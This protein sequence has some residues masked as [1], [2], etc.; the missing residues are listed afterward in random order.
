MITQEEQR[1]LWREAKRRDRAKSAIIYERTGTKIARD[2]GYYCFHNVDSYPDYKGFKDERRLT[3][4]EYVALLKDLANILI[5]FLL[6]NV[7]F[8]IVFPN[9]IMILG[10]RKNNTRLNDS[11]SNVEPIVDMVASK[12][13]GKRIYYMNLH[14]RGE[15]YKFHWAKYA[16]CY[17]DR[18]SFYFMRT[19]G[20]NSTRLTNLT[21]ITGPL[22]QVMQII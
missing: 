6:D 21:R 4:K 3:C 7:G 1:K 19:F 17:F 9:K 14:V 20:P 11:M 13:Y 5:T 15:Y 12:K 18:I 16:G 22:K 2:R 8:D 10:I